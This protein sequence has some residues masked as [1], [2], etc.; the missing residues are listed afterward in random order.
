MYGYK[1]D[2][3]SDKIIAYTEE[4]C[5]LLHLNYLSEFIFNKL[6][7]RHFARTEH[8]SSLVGLLQNIGSY[9]RL[10]NPKWRGKGKLKYHLHEAF[11]NI[12]FNLD[13]FLYLCFLVLWVFSLFLVL[14]WVLQML[15]SKDNPSIWISACI[16]I[17]L[18]KIDIFPHFMHDQLS[19]QFMTS[20]ST[21]CF[22]SSLP[23]VSI[24]PFIFNFC[25]QVKN[26]SICSSCSWISPSYLDVV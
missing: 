23:R 22:A 20:S 3:K 11:R 26:A 14:K 21:A 13:F 15:H 1:P 17:L 7:Y 5:K 16:F 10:W 25:A 8:L 18:F 19:S 2:K 9:W 12:E 4:N 6:N 24:I